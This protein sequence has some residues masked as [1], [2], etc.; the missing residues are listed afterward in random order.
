MAAKLRLFALEPV[1]YQRPFLLSFL[2][3]F[4]MVI[5][6]EKEINLEIGIKI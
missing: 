6:E 4:T 3:L 2:L 1:S 5:E